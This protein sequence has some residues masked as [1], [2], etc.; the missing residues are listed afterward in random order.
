MKKIYLLIV[1]LGIIQVGVSQ[2]LTMPLNYPHTGNY[3]EPNFMSVVDASHLWVGTTR[4]DQTGGGYLS[5]SV[6]IKTSDGGNT[7]QFD[8]IPVPG[9]PWMQD[10]EAWDSNICYYVF[11]DGVLYGGS[12][13]KTIDG[14]LTWSRKTSTQF[15]GGFADFIHLFSPDTCLALGDPTNGYFEVQLSNDGG[16]TWNRVPQANFP[17]ILTGEMGLAD[18]YSLVGNTI[19][20]GTSQGRC[21]KS[22]DR[23]N[24]W[25]AT[26][27]KS[28]FGGW[29]VCFSDTLHGI[30]YNGGAA[31]VYYLTADGGSTWAEEKFI[32]HYFLSDVSRV[33]SIYDGFIMSALDSLPPYRTSVYFTNDFFTSLINI[34]SNLVST[35]YIFFKNATTGW[36]SGGYYPDHNIFK[37]VD[38][39]S[40]I[41]AK[42]ISNGN[43]T[44]IPNPSHQ[45]AL[46]KFPSSYKGQIKLLKIIDFSSKIIEEYLLKPDDESINLNSSKYSNGTYN[47]ELIS[48][49]GLVINN[50]WIICH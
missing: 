36:L 9:V 47:I 21:F 40:S 29:R 18:E 12:I 10:V 2:F 43:L 35:G 17:P 44:I 16:N 30:F 42:I 6:A 4:V 25:T 28:S 13:W 49:D 27:V 31:T 48:E 22:V 46:V 5:Y 23:G 1:F 14:G 7:W 20:F 39:L 3:Y 33:D 41:P 38:V 19:W 45:N 32:P 26:M 8:S 50:R 11:T 15:S 37:F 24:H 34:E